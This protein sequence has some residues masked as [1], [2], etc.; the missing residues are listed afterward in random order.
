MSEDVTKARQV[1]EAFITQFQNCTE[2]T[3]RPSIPQVEAF[4]RQ[5]APISFEVQRQ[6]DALLNSKGLPSTTTGLHCWWEAEFAVSGDG[7]HHAHTVNFLLQDPC[8]CVVPH[9]LYA[10]EHAQREVD[11]RLVALRDAWLACDQDEV[12]F[13]EWLEDRE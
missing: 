3:D 10:I 12:R 7:P 9:L 5:F 6:I 1:A 2:F 4:M 13:H 8:T 11:A